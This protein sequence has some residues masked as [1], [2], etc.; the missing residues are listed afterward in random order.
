VFK[1]YVFKE[2]INW[3]RGPDYSKMVSMYQFFDF[4]LFF[5]VKMQEYGISSVENIAKNAYSRGSELIRPFFRE[6][7]L[8]RPQIVSYFF[9]RFFDCEPYR[10][11]IYYEKA[12]ITDIYAVN[13]A[14]MAI[15]SIK[16][17][18]LFTFTLK[19]GSRL[20]IF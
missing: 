10:D 6:D 18:N 12:L 1:I 4:Y 15:I 11:A 13:L 20:L 9:D 16:E 3:I 2:N 17:G 5:A 19:Y 8:R 14:H 7:R